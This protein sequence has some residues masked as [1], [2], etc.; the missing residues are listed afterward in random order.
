[1]N[2]LSKI[3]TIG[4]VLVSLTALG[5]C[6][7]GSEKQTLGT[8]LGG[9]A[10][11]WAGS[12]I[13]GGSGKIAAAAAGTLLGAL[14]GSEIGKTMDEVD[15]QK[16]AR[17]TQTALETNR[18]GAS[19]TWSNPDTGHSGSVTPTETYRTDDGRYCREFQQ[20]VTIGGET[21]NAYGTACRQPDGSWEIVS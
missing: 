9:A 5:D 4:V 13:G 12:Q 11:G 16:A 21:Q 19:S 8:V 7:R 20:T 1:M 17:A 10:G 15:R 2:R 18:T 6:Q 14:I 3:A